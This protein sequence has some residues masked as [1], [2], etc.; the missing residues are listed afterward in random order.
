M[1]ELMNKDGDAD[2]QLKI[3]TLMESG[4]GNPLHKVP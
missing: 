4:K 3:T 1:M 2:G